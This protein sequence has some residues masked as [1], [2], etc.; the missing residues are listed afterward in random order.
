MTPPSSPT[1]QNGGDTDEIRMLSAECSRLKS[2]ILRRSKGKTRSSSSSASRRKIRELERECERLK[3]ALKKAVRHAEDDDR[4]KNALMDRDAMKTQMKIQNDDVNL[5]I[6][7][8]KERDAKLKRAHAAEQKRLRKEITVL[9]EKYERISREFKESRQTFEIRIQ[10][11]TNSI[12]IIR[13]REENLLRENETL[14]QE[15]E[16]MREKKKDGGLSQD[17]ENNE[18]RKMNATLSEQVKSTTMEVHKLAS[19]RTKLEQELRKIQD[20]RSELEE[21][22]SNH[23]SELDQK[24]SNH[25]SELERGYSGHIARLEEEHSVAS[26]NHIEKHYRNTIEARRELVHADMKLRNAKIRHS[27]SLKNVRRESVSNV[28]NM[29][30]IAE[31]HAERH[32]SVRDELSELEK[33]HDSLMRSRAIGEEDEDEKMREMNRLEREIETLKTLHEVRL[34]RHL[35]DLSVSHQK[36]QIETENRHAKKLETYKSEASR[37]ENELEQVRWDLNMSSARESNVSTEMDRMREDHQIRHDKEIEVV[38]EFEMLL[39]TAEERERSGAEELILDHENAIEELRE[40]HQSALQHHVSTEM[41]RVREHH[42]IRHEKE[43]EVVRELEMQLSKAEE[44]ERSG[45][46]E[47]SITKAIEE[48]S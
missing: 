42:Q 43:I 23:V 27:E 9:E 11:M 4:L 37:L 46:R 17:E 19:E 13:T 21:K 26:Q 6:S 20:E 38:R 24:Y 3:R 15:I 30:R 10:E 41:E 47:Y 22:Y 18:L 12:E 28:E 5:A 40:A 48:R 14:R 39:S 31:E 7:E 1:K 33:K 45:A 35:G 34:K 29:R 44:K 32:N 16:R 25:I 8:W 36:A 2:I